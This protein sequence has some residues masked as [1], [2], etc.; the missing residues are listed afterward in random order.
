M[1]V[2]QARDCRREG[3]LLRHRP[4]GHRISPVILGLG[5]LG[6]CA[7]P[8]P[9]GSP[10]LAPRA[11]EAIDPRVPVPDALVVGPADATLK[12][13]L[14]ALVDQATS[15]DAAFRGVIDNAERLAAAAG[16]QSS[17]SWIAAQQ[18]LSVAQG[19]RVRRRTRLAT[20]TRLHRRR[21]KRRAASKP[22]ISPRFRR[23]QG[24]FRQSI[25]TSPT[26]SMRSRSAS[27][28]S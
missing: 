19:A 12:S 9:A 3:P 18:A 25:R 21:W 26:V 8:M 6:A 20:S 13:K 28:S 4:C 2:R 10:S 11:A 27:A 15:G 7:T 14:A 24:L 22:V 5:L 17:E 23:P 16:A 1:A